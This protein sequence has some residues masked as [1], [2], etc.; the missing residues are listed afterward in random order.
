MAT[1]CEGCGIEWNPEHGTIRCLAYIIYL[2]VLEF[3][4]SIKASLYNEHHLKYL[5]DS[6]LNDINCAGNI[7]ATAF[8]KI[9][10]SLLSK[11]SIKLIYIP[12]LDPFYCYYCQ[13]ISLEKGMIPKTPESIQTVIL[14]PQGQPKTTMWVCHAVR[15]CQNLMIKYSWYAEE[16]MRDV[17]C[18]SH[19]IAA[20]YNISH[21]QEPAH[22]W[23]WVV[24]Y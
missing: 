2:C 23:W 19:M 11:W 1:E 10:P 17:R 20:L 14:Q 13:L 9:S 8:V 21:L 7:F 12:L 3:L 15:G 16:S 24:L 22:E 6:Y 5:D 4:Q 18:Y